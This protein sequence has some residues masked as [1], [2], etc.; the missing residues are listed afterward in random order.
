MG[1][2]HVRDRLTPPHGGRRETR[3]P[4][5][6][7]SAQERATIGSNPFNPGKPVTHRTEEVARM[8]QLTRHCAGCSE[9]RL[10]EPFHAE[11]ASCPDAPDGECQEWGCTVCGDALIIGLPVPSYVSSDSTSRAA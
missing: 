3:P 7:E 9:E 10:F 5:S 1:D 11:P 2:G 6:H 4:R 8:T